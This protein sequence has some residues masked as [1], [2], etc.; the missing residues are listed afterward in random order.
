[1]AA[2]PSPEV[3]RDPLARSPSSRQLKLKFD[4]LQEQNDSAKLQLAEE[5]K[6]VFLMEE[7]NRGN[8]PLPPPF[9]PLSSTFLLTSLP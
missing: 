6:A 3:G 2:Q 1:M 9:S 8:P 5:R 7:K 4:S